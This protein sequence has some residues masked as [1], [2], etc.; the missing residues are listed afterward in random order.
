MNKTAILLVCVALVGGVAFIFRGQIFTALFTPNDMATGKKDPHI[1]LTENNL[2]YQQANSLRNT[3]DAKQVIELYQKALDLAADPAE[4]GQI[5]FMIAAVGSRVDTTASI[6]QLKELATDTTQS[7][8]Q[9]AYAV[10]QLGQN[11]YRNTNKDTIG[12][13]FS[14]EPYAGFYKE[15]DVRLAMR[16]LF[17]YASSFHPLAISE[18]RA[19][20]WY[21]DAVYDLKR[22]TVLT[23][24][25]RIRVD[26][27]LS[28]IREKFALA[29]A[30]IERTRTVTNGQ[31]LIPEALARKAGV[32]GRLAL[33]SEES[34]ADPEKAFA[35]AIN[36][37]MPLRDDGPVRVNYAIYL[38]NRYGE[39]RRD[40]SIAILKPL[41][42]NIESYPEGTKIF[43]SAERNNILGSKADL[44]SLA[45]SVPD[46]KKMLLS[47]GWSETDFAL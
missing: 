4:R 26:S 31:K 2:F 29:D 44:V 7:N 23:E 34:F 24:E 3:G 43:L 8:L 10:Q 36:A 5:Q 1:R 25:E 6:R 30:D 16:R 11:Y 41:I 33:A 32:L 12:L 46:F 18:L 21:A 19:A 38:A 27:Y 40:D 35:E 9:R 14:G 13:I 37:N 45:M 42:S 22:K 39:S 17:E 47:L 15:K 20:R 28:I